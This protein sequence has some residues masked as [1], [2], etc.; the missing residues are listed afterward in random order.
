MFI[1]SSICICGIRPHTWYDTDT[2]SILIQTSGKSENF[3][4]GPDS[5]TF[6]FYVSFHLVLFPFLKKTKKTKKHDADY[7]M[8][9]MVKPTIKMFVEVKTCEL[10]SL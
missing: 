7:S 10:L 5:D 4:T 2:P 1:N 3:P 6:Y 8:V 9:V